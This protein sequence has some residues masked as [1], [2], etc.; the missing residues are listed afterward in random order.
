MRSI[1][2][3]F[4]WLVWVLSV[5]LVFPHGAVV[6]AQTQPAQKTQ[7]ATKTQTPPATATKTQPAATKASA[8]STPPTWTNADTG[9]PRPVQLKTGT[10][11]WYQPQVESWTDQKYIV[12]WSAVSYQPTGAQ[13]PALGTIK[14]EGPTSAS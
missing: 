2:R 9:W 3:R 4:A 10:V 5:A 11:L 1:T 8:A 6:R 12:A 13:Q 14:I 7:P